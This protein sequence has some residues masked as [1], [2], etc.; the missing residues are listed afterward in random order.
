MLIFYS[1]C[2]KTNKQ[3]WDNKD[4]LTYL[5]FYLQLHGSKPTFLRDGDTGDNHFNW[6]HIMAKPPF[7]LPFTPKAALKFQCKLLKVLT[8]QLQ[9]VPAIC[10]LLLAG[11]NGCCIGAAIR[12]T[13]SAAKP[14]LASQ[15][16]WTPLKLVHRMGDNLRENQGNAVLYIAGTSRSRTKFQCF[17]PDFHTRSDHIENE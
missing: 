1:Y 11:W 8:Y 9:K 2:F 14:L 4:F 5:N 6:W 13:T 17:W 7:S 15:Y 3:T 12:L 16:S 10:R